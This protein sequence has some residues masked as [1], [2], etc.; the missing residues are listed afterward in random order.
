MSRVIVGMADCRVERDPGVV[1]TT[2]ALGSCIG[3]VV[4]DPVAFVGGLLHFM[5]P[6]SQLDPI[7]GRERPYM[8]A[9]I[10]IPLLIDQLCAQGANRGRL[11]VCAVGAAQILDERGIFEIGKRNY[12]ATRR[13]LWKLGVMLASEAIGGVISRNVSL[14]I[15]TGKLLLQEGGRQQ[16]IPLTWK[17]E[18]GPTWL[19]AS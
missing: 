18:G 9:D 10:G 5:L 7:R 12:Q 6:D 19:I 11:V 8:F 1:L 4:Y 15:A 16:E 17:K 3:L 13:L 2:Y 14:E